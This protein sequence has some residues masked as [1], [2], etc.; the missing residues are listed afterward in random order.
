MKPALPRL[1]ERSRVTGSFVNAF[2]GRY[3]RISNCDRM[4]AFFMNVVS[5][6]DLWLFLASNGGLTAGRVDA[7]HALFPYQTVDRI[8]DSAGLV[9]PFS[10]LWVGSDD[11]KIFWEP[12]ASHRPRMNAITR[13]IY[14]SVEGDRVWFE[15]I[16]H[17]LG[18][19]F[20]YGWSTAEAHGFVRRCEVENLKNRPVPVRVIDGLRNL[21]PPGIPYRL[22]SESSCLVDAYKTAELLSGTSLAVYALAAGIVDRAIPVE[23]L[24]ASIVWSEGLPEADILLSDAQLNTFYAEEK[25]VM[26]KHQRGVRAT[27]AVSSAFLL[28]PRATQRWL[29]V[30]DT[31]LTQ[32]VV[33]ERRRALAAGGLTAAVLTAVDAS[34]QSLR[35]LVGSADG[36]QAGGTE[37]TTAHHFANVLFN[38]MRGGIFVDG[39]H[40]PGRG[41]A[42][43]VRARNRPVAARH[44]DFLAGLPGTLPRAGFLTLIAARGDRDLERLGLE[45]LPLTFSRR[46]GDPSRPWNRFRIRVRDEHNER[47]L[48]HEGNWRDI[49]QNWEALCLSFP[50]FLESIIAKFVN[51]STVDG[52]NPYRVSH[53]GIEWEVPDHDN[54]WA[55]IG[56]WGD[57]QVVYLLRL[58]EWSGRFHP[59]RLEAWLR[60]DLFSY[61]NVPYRILGYAAIQQN[62]HATIEFA[63]A[64]HNAIELLA[65][66]LGTDARLVHGAAGGVLHVN[67]TEKLLILILTRLTNFVPGG[68]IWMNTQR[69]EW[70]DANNA[71]V[72]Y[73][74]SV[75]TLCNLRR[76]L[77]YCLKILPA[78]GSEPV[79]VS[80]AVAALLPRVLAALETHQHLLAQPT[81]TDV[82]RRAL[83][84]LLANAGSDYRVNVYRNG[85][86]L[87]TAVKPVDIIQLIKRSLAFTD[88]TIRL[89]LRSDGLYHAYNLLEFTEQPA[90]LKI[91]RLAPMLEGQVAVLSAG[92]L[93]ADEAVSLMTALRHSPLYRADQHSYLLYPDRRTPDFLERN[94][95]PASVVVTCPLLKELCAAGDKRLVL[96]DVDG[97]HRFHPDLVNGAA[98][99]ERLQILAADPRW[100]EALRIH[101]PQ[102]KAIYE[103]VFNHRAF[104]G[105]SGSMFGYEGLGCIYW[106][107]VAKLLLAVQENLQSALAVEH[108]KAA[109]LAEIYYDVRAGLGFNK[110]PAVY[111]AFPTD[112]YS[113]TPGHSGAQQP[114]MTGQV[115]EELLTRFGELGVRVAQ[116]TITFA[117]KFLRETEF[118][119]A[120]SV[121]SYVDAAGREAEFEL[122]EG[123]LAFTFCGVPVVYHR[124]ARVARLRIRSADQGGRNCSGRSL[125]AATS[126]LIFARSGS[127]ARI[128]VELGAG[129]RPLPAGRPARQTRRPRATRA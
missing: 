2:G 49:F 69:P 20:R 23:S 50:E 91:H 35:T 90:A 114:G 26:E 40:M 97:R 56:Y 45:Y 24:R 42:A 53:A 22:Q 110:A 31:G 72:G 63:A 70:N 118:T 129:A 123:T 93:H 120:P 128:D 122:P 65:G 25:P 55:T 96:C 106:H 86:G 64:Q 11:Q 28:A 78:L 71:L 47:V 75:V 125:D 74:V 33:A 54:P 10:A 113:H 94:V 82:D 3:Y 85:L 27:Y 104:T 41:F 66:Q 76:L 117:P 99:D 16:H 115:K 34:T 59:G 4:P 32:A 109:Q 108:A 103:Q 127:I 14:K 15:E 29:I 87:P 51:A 9:G 73:G 37:T 88:H 21:L 80:G 43:F 19:A 68:G 18:L 83:L 61:A 116:G 105:R 5:S 62:P 112:P 60:R 111:G 107:M 89:N 101:S 57:H 81:I 6:S 48:N 58:L 44:A 121:F 119:T 79:P 13:N 100:A 52:Y 124:G 126:A 77:V 46:H 67:L 102:V 98:L 1:S 38:I 30:A 84:D 95:I 36:L 8:Y 39:H 7:E 92:L 12:F 17:L